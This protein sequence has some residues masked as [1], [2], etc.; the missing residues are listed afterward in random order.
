MSGAEDSG[1][2]LNAVLN[3]RPPPFMEKVERHFGD[4]FSD[5]NVSCCLKRVAVIDLTSKEW[6]EI[7]DDQQGQ[8]ERI[9]SAYDAPS[10]SFRC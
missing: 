1:I 3:P 4:N 10:H 5:G 6:T 8:N 7:G 9:K 2:L